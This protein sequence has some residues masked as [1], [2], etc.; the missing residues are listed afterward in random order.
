M[1]V[2]EKFSG[3]YQANLEQGISN[4]NFVE[5]FS[6]FSGHSADCCLG[7]S[8]FFGRKFEF[9][10]YTSPFHPSR[11]TPLQHFVSNPHA[12]IRCWHCAHFSAASSGCRPY[13]RSSVIGKTSV[14]AKLLVPQRVIATLET[15]TLKTT[16]VFLYEKNR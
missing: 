9:W 13:P 7:S 4:I 2:F 16:V 12:A 15:N 11:K 10:T 1:Q 14:Y 3:F 8:N 5:S 6:G